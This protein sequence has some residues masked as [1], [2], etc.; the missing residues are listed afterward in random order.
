MRIIV[1]GAT[2]FIGTAVIG[3]LLN[4]GHE[5]V[6]V[7]RPSSKNRTNLKAAKLLTI[8]DLDIQDVDRLPELLDRA[9]VFL[10]L[11]WDGIGSTGRQDEGI[12]QQNIM[13]SLKAV[14]AA[15]AVGCRRF[16]FSG[17][18]A[19]YGIGHPILAEDTACRPVS[20][21][22]KAKLEFGNQAKA[23]CKSLKMSYIHTRIFSVYGPGDHPWSLVSSCLSAW[24]HEE[25]IQ[26]GE[27]T[28]AWNYLYIDDA[29]R[30]LMVL[31]QEGM[32]GI[33]NIAGEDTRPL[34]A[35]IEEMYHICGSKG[36]YEYGVREPN[37]EGPVSLIP[38]T[39]KI[40]Q[41]TGWKPQ[42]TFAEGIY[43]T[44]QGMQRGIV[45]SAAA[46]A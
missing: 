30:A 38:S 28:Q 32:S 9:D 1:T 17:S 10:H 36:S 22:G 12:Q 5:V 13:H 45:R 33:Y 26:L 27:C 41:E 16:L 4:R 25:R 44:L 14:A 43:E 24:Q 15:A 37:A 23:L 21:Y 2:S 39:V 19:E 35:Y 31:M 34:R 42:I 40:R 6:A 20:A 46:E 8:L 29:A 18:Q 7:I 3:Q 11:A